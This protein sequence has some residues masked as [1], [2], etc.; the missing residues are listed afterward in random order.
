MFTAGECFN[1]I[2]NSNMLIFP[3]NFKIGEAYS[4]RPGFEVNM[5]LRIF[6]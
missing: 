5:A 2:F 6:R 3:D 4:G 1:S